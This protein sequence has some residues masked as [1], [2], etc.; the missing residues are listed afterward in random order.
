[1]RCNIQW[2]NIQSL[3]Q[4]DYYSNL[5]MSMNYID[6]LTQSIKENMDLNGWGFQACKRFIDYMETR[7][8]SADQRQIVTIAS[9]VLQGMSSETICKDKWCVCAREVSNLLKY[10][11]TCDQIGRRT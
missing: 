4:S 11:L 8:T 5:V 2:K 10:S 7:A 9:K 3:G 1:M 6:Q